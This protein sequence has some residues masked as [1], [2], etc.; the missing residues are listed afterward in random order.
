VA[1]RRLAAVVLVLVLAG[2]VSAAAPAERE[3]AWTRA[4]TVVRVVS[5]DTLDVRLASGARERVRL[6]GVR[7]PAA[8]GC[9]AA[10]ARGAARVLAGGR[11]V[12]LGADRAVPARD[13]ARR[14][15]VYV[16]PGRRGDLGR[17]LLELGLAQIDPGA[18]PFG[19]FLDYVPAQRKAQASGP[20]GIGRG[21]WTKCGADVGVTIVASPAEPVV[22]EKVTYRVTVGNW[23]PLAAPG[24]VLELRPPAATPLE[25]ADLAGCRVEAWVGTCSFRRLAPRGAA[26]ATFTA[27]VT[28]AGLVSARVAA[29]FDWCIKASCG[30]TPLRDSNAQNN[31]SAA[32]VTAVARPVAGDPPPTSTG[33]HPSYPTVCIPPPPPELVCADLPFR[34]FS[35]RWTVP[36]PDPHHLDKSED[37][38]GCQ[39]DDY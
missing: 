36:D 30:T 26:T 18:Q 9:L 5:G 17:E 29:R 22:G 14:L 10:E 15:L 6:L 32:L 19:R 23:G 37:G 31:E 38:I 24:V 34:E 13:G 21:L 8:G 27:S 2:V 4:A 3:R 11:P 20:E 28:R 12:L 25:R 35:V 33:C 7:A 39:F 16:A 1:V